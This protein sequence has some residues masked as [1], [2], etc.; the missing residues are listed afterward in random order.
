MHLWDHLLAFG[1]GA[2]LIA[3]ATRKA[4][5]RNRL[6]FGSLLLAFGLELSQH[7]VYGTPLEWRDVLMDALG[8]SL[9]PLLVL[10]RHEPR[11]AIDRYPR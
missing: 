6:L 1:V 3:N 2:M 7:F 10:L 4:S 8:L 5:V 11:Q 9:C